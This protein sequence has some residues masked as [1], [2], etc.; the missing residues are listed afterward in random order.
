M[1]LDT[2]PL[3]SAVKCEPGTDI[4][5]LI[6]EVVT[7]LKK[8]GI[9]IGGVLQTF[10][11]DENARSTCLNVVDI[12]TEKVARITQDRGRNA[13]GC[14]LDP[15]GLADISPYVREAIDV[16]VELI[17]INKFGIAESEGEGLL[18]C[19]AEAVCANIPVLTT[20]RE[21]Y[22]DAWRSFHGGFAIE[23]PPVKDNIVAWCLAVCGRIPRLDRGAESIS[24]RHRTLL[25]FDTLIK[26]GANS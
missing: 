4:N 18:S 15:R 6:L 19:M 3:L 20:V 22:L 24:E 8:R 25:H 7:D 23:L 5:P 2:I 17:V 26:N 16:G 12:R 9:E 10:E 1:S 13:Q 11:I 14:K 21:P